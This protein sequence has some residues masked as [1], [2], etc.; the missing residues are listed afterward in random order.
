MSVAFG[1]S[2]LDRKEICAH[3]IYNRYDIYWFDQSLPAGEPD[4]KVDK[5]FLCR[6][7]VLFLF[8]I[9]E[10]RENSPVIKQARASKTTRLWMALYHIFPN[11]TQPKDYKPENSNSK[12]VARGIDSLHLGYLTKRHRKTT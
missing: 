9:R 11:H 10:E 3:V 5:S 2:V 8:W 6:G 7:G 12:P 4:P 1:V